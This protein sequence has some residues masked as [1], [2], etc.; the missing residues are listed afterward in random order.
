MDGLVHH[1]NAG[2]AT[3]MPAATV[4]AGPPAPNLRGFSRVAKA[5]KTRSEAAAALYATLCKICTDNGDDPLAEVDL[6]DPDETHS[7]W[8]EVWYEGHPEALDHW[9]ESLEING[10]WG[11]FNA[12]NSFAVTLCPPSADNVDVPNH[13]RGEL[14]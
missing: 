3:V 12:V 14:V 13:V 10:D 11:Y 7:G 5:C 4:N 2:A 6:L 9:A 8:W 1:E